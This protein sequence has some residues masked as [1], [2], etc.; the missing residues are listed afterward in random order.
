MWD[1][2]RSELGLEHNACTI[3]RG[4]NQHGNPITGFEDYSIQR[5]ASVGNLEEHRPHHARATFE[6]TRCA[7]DLNPGLV[8]WGLTSSNEY[9]G[10]LLERTWVHITLTNCRSIDGYIESCTFFFGLAWYARTRLWISWFLF[11]GGGHFSFLTLSVIEHCKSSTCSA[12]GRTFTCARVTWPARI[13]FAA[14]E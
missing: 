7:C 2:S 5:G 4:D 11:G 9:Y 12:S 14:A 3:T 6:P 10:W 13:Y 8:T 1:T